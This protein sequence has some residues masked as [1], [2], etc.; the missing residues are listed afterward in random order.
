MATQDKQ[1]TGPQIPLQPLRTLTD[2]IFALAMML[3]LVFFPLP[4]STDATQP[5]LYDF[6]LQE[7]F[8]SVLI[9]AVTFLTLAAYWISHRRLSCYLWRTDQNYLWL[10]ILYLLFVVL[11]AYSGA[12]AMAFPS[13]WLTNGLLSLN[14]MLIG[15]AAYLGWIYATHNRRLVDPD[16]TPAVVLAEKKQLLI[17]PLTALGAAMVALIN[18]VLWTPA[19][20]VLL[21]IGNFTIKGRL[22]PG[23][24]E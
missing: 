18:P 19:F 15:V 3:M 7:L 9:F 2:S 16:L 20:V 17:E 4:E 13:Y 24:G 10:T 6:L 23:G 1:P 21:L 14:M 5:E 22:G 8:P 12:L 11:I